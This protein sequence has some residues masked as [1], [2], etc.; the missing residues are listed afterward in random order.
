MITGIDIVKEMIKVSAGEPLSFKQKDVEINGHAIECSICAED[1]ENNFIPTPGTAAY[2]KSP[3]G[4]GVRDDS[5]LFNGYQVTTFYDP[6]LSKLIVWGKD[7][8]D[9]I[10]RM[11]RALDEYIVLGLKTNLGFLN[12]LMAE[13]DFIAGKLDTGFIDKH[14]KLLKIPKESLEI[15]SIAGVITLHTATD[16]QSSERDPRFTPWKYIARRSSV[17]RN[18]MF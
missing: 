12:R 18:S 13:K 9:A 10:K 2:T 17:S 6:M 11:A 14:K 16:S 15:S 7:R 5:S 4:P 8:N 1:P 3:Q